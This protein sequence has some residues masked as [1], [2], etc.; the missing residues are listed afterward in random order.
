MN[1]RAREILSRL[2][3]VN[4]YQQ[5]YSLQ[6]LAELHGV[7]SRTIRYDLSQI[8]EF[9]QENGI[10]KITLSSGGVLEVPADISRC[11]ETLPQSVFYSLKLSKSEKTAMILTI[12]TFVDEFITLSELALA[13]DLMVSRSTLIQDVENAKTYVTGHNLV[14]NSYPNHGIMLEGS[15]LDKRRMLLRLIHGQKSVFKPG[16]LLEHLLSVQ[17]KKTGIMAERDMIEKIVNEAEH[18]SGQF[19][20]DLDFHF[21]VTYIM[22]CCVRLKQGSVITDYVSD[23]SEMENMACAILMQIDNFSQ[24]MINSGEIAFLSKILSKLRY[25]KKTE[26]DNDIVKIQIVTRKFIEEVSKKLGM[27]LKQDYIFYENLSNHLASTFS[28]V[29]SDIKNQCFYHS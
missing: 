13:D 6:Q 2:M 16:P 9:L 17:E 22:I 4:G 27:D 1:K 12:L 14:L 8:N 23:S 25:L 7:S 19:L 15:E 24:I 20:T 11:E 5:S 3:S 26:P 28:E 21:L 10:S 18:I 29:I